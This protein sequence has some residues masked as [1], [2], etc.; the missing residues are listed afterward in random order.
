MTAVTPQTAALPFRLHAEHTQVLLITN[1]AGEWAIPKGHIDAG[2]TPPE[3]AIV[4][5]YEEAGVRGVIEGPRLAT[6]TYDK[7]DGRTC[8]VEAF[9]LRV[10]EI[11][12]D[13]P[14][15]DDRDRA[16]HAI[17]DAFDHLELHGPRRALT[18]L[19]ARLAERTRA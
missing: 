5:S 3:M 18:A 6:Y 8:R 19:A 17:E 13:W 11:L 12:D 16:W 1:S 15:C 9:A 14:E 2:F 4:E 7:P 10:T